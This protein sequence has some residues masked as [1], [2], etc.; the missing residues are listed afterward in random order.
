M[1]CAVAKENSFL[2]T[3]N[4]KYKLKP[5]HY[6]RTMGSG[7]RNCIHITM[8]CIGSTRIHRF[9]VA[10][11]VGDA[12]VTMVFLDSAADDARSFAPRPYLGCISSIDGA[13]VAAAAVS[14]DLWDDG[15]AMVMV[16]KSRRRGGEE[17]G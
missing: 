9:C 7:A 13:G 16:S 14:F 12:C 2:A 8:G 10:I 3:A 15:A 17:A 11:D 1:L 5:Y 6:F 4:P